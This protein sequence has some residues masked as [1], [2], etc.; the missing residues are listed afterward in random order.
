VLI[1]G[2]LGQDVA[3]AGVYSMWNEHLY[4]EVTAYRF[5]QDRRFSFDSRIELSQNP[6]FKEPR[7]HFPEADLIGINPTRYDRCANLQPRQSEGSSL[8]RFIMGRLCN[9]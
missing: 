6:V 7:D 3:G 2:T 8:S 4:T 5:R 1:D 9:R